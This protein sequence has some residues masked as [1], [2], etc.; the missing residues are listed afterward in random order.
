MRTDIDENA[1]RYYDLSLD[2]P[3][4]IPFYEERI[5]SPEARILE[6]GC[7]TGR[8]LVPLAGKCA[9]ILGVDISAS[10]LALC[11]QKLAERGIP[12]SRAEVRQ[13]DITDL[14]LGEKFD[15]IIAPFRVFQTLET[16]EEVSGFFKTVRNHLSH[17]GR[18]ILD[19]RRPRLD[20]DRLRREWVVDAERFHWEVPIEGGRVTLHDRRP[21]MD[22]ERLV[23]YPE[24]IF[25][26]YEDDQLVDEAILKVCLRCYYPEQLPNLIAAQGFRI[27]SIWGG[28]AGEPYGEGPEL[29]VE[30]AGS[31]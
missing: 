16:D 10:M 31:A 19:A 27:V 5:P 1:A 21:R 17:G 28:Y 11:C 13:E 9:H 18:A 30:Y 20:A 8:V 6:L 24:L 15:L 23:L 29:I 3:D 14:T 12:L 4:D 7:G 25:R 2:H 26:R 22:P